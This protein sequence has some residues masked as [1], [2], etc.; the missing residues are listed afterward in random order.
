MSF[1]KIIKRCKSSAESSINV[2]D[3]QISFV[4]RWLQVGK[5]CLQGSSDFELM[6]WMII[7]LFLVDDFI[8][9]VF[10]QVPISF[11]IFDELIFLHAPRMNPS[12]DTYT[13]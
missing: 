2:I 9:F 8:T 11:H 4:D 5:R 13:N 3:V 6:V 7:I 1:T 10:F 12:L